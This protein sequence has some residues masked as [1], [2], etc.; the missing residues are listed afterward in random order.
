[1][2]AVLREIKREAEMAV[3]QNKNLVTLASYRIEELK[4]YQKENG[5]ETEEE[6]TQEQ[7]LKEEAMVGII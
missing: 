1:M 2:L 4:K 6:Y 3:H 7:N 5:I